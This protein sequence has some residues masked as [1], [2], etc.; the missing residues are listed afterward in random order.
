MRSF[1]SFLSVLE[2][3]AVTLLLLVLALLSKRLGAVTHRSRVYRWLYVAAFLASFSA[4][5]RIWSLTLS[6]DDFVAISGNVMALVFY[7]LPLALSVSI[8]VLV[9]WR[10]WG[11][12]IY[13]KDE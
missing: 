7:A 8:G 6:E 3:I 9:S 10:Y 4:V 12:L 13:T 11:W 1:F 5:T 2:P